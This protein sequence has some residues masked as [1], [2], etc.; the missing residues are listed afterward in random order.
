MN[1]FH[2]GGRVFKTALAVTLAIFLAQQFGLE[3]VTLAAI[4]ALLTV[5]RTFFHS[6]VQSLVKLGSVLIGG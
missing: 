1:R 3:R 4:I 2:V 6:L 5:Q